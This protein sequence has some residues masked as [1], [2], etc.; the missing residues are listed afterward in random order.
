[1]I[2]SGM[3][4]RRKA[5]CGRWTDGEEFEDNDTEVLLSQ[6]IAYACGCRAFR[7]EYHDGSVS[8]KVTRHDGA[9]LVDEMLSAE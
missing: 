5:P 7:H 8:S 4:S 2:A 6:G 3:F 1:M 9:V